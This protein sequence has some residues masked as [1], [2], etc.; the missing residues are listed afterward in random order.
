MLPQHDDL[1]FDADVVS[2]IPEGETRLP[3]PVLARGRFILSQQLLAGDGEVHGS[4]MLD[5]GKWRWLVTPRQEPWGGYKL[6]FREISGCKDRLPG[7]TE[8]RPSVAPQDEDHWVEY[9][10]GL[11][12]NILPIDGLP[13]PDPDTATTKKTRGYRLPPQLRQRDTANMYGA[14][15]TQY[16]PASV[17]TGQMREGAQCLHHRGSQSPFG[18][19]H[20]RTHGIVEYPHPRV[21]GATEAEERTN[22]AARKTWLV[23]ISSAGV[24]ATRIRHSKQCCDSW[25]PFWATRSEDG[26]YSFVPLSTKYDALIAEDPTQTRILRLLTG[27]AVSAAY[28]GGWTFSQLPLSVGG[29]SLSDWTGWAF[30]YSGHEAQNV[31]FTKSGAG[32]MTA[33]RFKITFSVAAGPPV[34]IAAAFSEEE[35][36]DILAPNNASLFKFRRPYQ[37]DVATDTFAYRTAVE[38]TNNPTTCDAPIYVFYTGDTERVARCILGAEST[39]TSSSGSSPPTGYTLVGG[40]PVDPLIC[41][42]V[43][44]GWTNTGG[45]GSGST[46]I[47]QNMQFTLSGEITLGG[48]RLIDGSTVWS[49]LAGYGTNTGSVTIAANLW[50]GGAACSAPPGVFSVGG[51]VVGSWSRTFF[52][53]ETVES[54]HT[55]N[56]TFEITL[57]MLDREAIVARQTRVE[58]LEVDTSYGTFT[59]QGVISWVGGGAEWFD[60]GGVSLGAWPDSAPNIPQTPFGGVPPPP[61]SG[62]FS[63]STETEHDLWLT[64]RSETEQVGNEIVVSP[65]TAT[66]HIDAVLF[67]GGGL[68]Y[69]DPTMDP[70]PS[71]T[72][73][74]K[75]TYD[76]PLPFT[77]ALATDLPADTVVAPAGFDKPDVYPAGWIGRI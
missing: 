57:P 58:T 73:K 63:S 60:S 43:P 45:A 65:A 46:T 54:T 38:G 25:L 18:F 16:V 52:A 11:S 51:N 56:W 61:P 27:G 42:S 72:T 36:E 71:A 69:A 48:T 19:T 31:I 8:F 77:P 66:K 76:K 29:S 62:S 67:I 26:D 17:Y 34:S 6:I 55:E 70:A 4:F 44:V 28:S 47:T 37:Y 13:R 20:A 3:G 68:Y 9:A 1:E 39:V 15:T 33:H 75:L 21:V 32:R 64:G 24:Y 40:G 7:Y 12:E 2:I 22:A 53:S 14:G 35:S 74:L 59:S 10:D 5:Y 23:E 30:S 50:P 49:D 41:A